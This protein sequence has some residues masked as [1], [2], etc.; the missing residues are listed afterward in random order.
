MKTFRIALLAAALL[1]PFVGCGG[2]E[3][4]SGLPADVSDQP[5]DTPFAGEG[6]ADTVLDAPKLEPPSNPGGGPDGR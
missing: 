5:S 3:G 2:P 4:E 6:G 1:I